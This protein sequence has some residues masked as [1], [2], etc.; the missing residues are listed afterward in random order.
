MILV[1]TYISWLIVTCHVCQIQKTQ[2]ILIPPI[3]VMPAPLFSKVYMDTM[4]MPLSNGYKYIVQGC[5][6]LIH[7]PEWTQL[8]RESA[9]A[10]ELWI[11]HDIIYRWGCLLWIVTDN[12]PTFLAALRWLEKHYGMKHIR[13]SGYNSHANG[14][15]ECAHYDV[16][17]AVFKAC[18]RDEN[19]WS[20]HTY[21][22]FWAEC[23]TIQR[24]M[25]CSPYFSAHGT[26]LLLLLNIAESNYLLPLPAS[27]LTSKELITC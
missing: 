26:H 5:C 15:V 17:E 9:K 2:Q 18:D 23:V 14:I 20:A 27:S 11:L 24:C 10:I 12:G 19:P 4:H 16:R 21:S 25:G 3:I 1:A 7:Y 13:I 22:I 6:S 8:K